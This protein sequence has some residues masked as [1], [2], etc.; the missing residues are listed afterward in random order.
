MDRDARAPARPH[1]GASQTR[2]KAA[3]GARHRVASSAAV[4]RKV[5]CHRNSLAADS[6]HRPVAAR[7]LDQ[8]VGPHLEQL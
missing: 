3:S 5:N 7:A 1:F 4:K 6:F 2:P 8:R